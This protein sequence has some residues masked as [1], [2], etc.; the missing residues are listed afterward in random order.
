VRYDEGITVLILHHTVRP[1]CCVRRTLRA[2]SGATA[3]RPFLVEVVI[4]GPAEDVTWLVRGKTN[5]E[6]VRVD[7]HKNLGMGVPIAAAT[8]RFLKRDHRW[9]M[10]LDDDMLLRKGSIDLAIESMLREQEHGTKVDRVM[11]ANKNSKPVG[12]RLEKREGDIPA[13]HLDRG[14]A[15]WSRSV[16]PDLTWSVSDFVDTGCTIFDRAALEDGCMPDPRFFVGS[17]SVDFGWNALQRGYL[18]VMYEGSKADHI[19][20]QCRSIEHESV[21]RGESHVRENGRIFADK[22]GIEPVEITGYK[23]KLPLEK[24]VRTAPPDKD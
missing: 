13:L 21:R 18:S 12:L 19:S 7:N 15:L 24:F 14:K 20:R 1:R 3:I 10:R 2:L 8:E 22:W 5:F 17:F 11:I 16:R 4:Q 9:M 23:R 6:L